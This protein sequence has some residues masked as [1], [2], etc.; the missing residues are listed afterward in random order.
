MHEKTAN[1]KQTNKRTAQRRGWY[2]RTVDGLDGGLREH[3]LGGHDGEVAKVVVPHIRHLDRLL[4][5]MIC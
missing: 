3:G 1:N 4:R 2:A 5:R